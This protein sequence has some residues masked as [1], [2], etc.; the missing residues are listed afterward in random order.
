MILRGGYQRNAT[1]KNPI[2]W[3][4]ANDQLLNL[5][6]NAQEEQLP[7]DVDMNRW[8]KLLSLDMTKQNTVYQVD[9]KFT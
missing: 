5:M 3:N 8:F 2:D 9:P 4:Q 1:I 6:P 7:L